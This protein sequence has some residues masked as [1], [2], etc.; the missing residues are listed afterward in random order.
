M[1]EAGGALSIARQLARQ[2]ARPS[3]IDPRQVRVIKEPSRSTQAA[4]NQSHQ[5]AIEE[6]SSS[7]HLR[8]V[9]RADQ[10]DYARRRREHPLEL[11]AHYGAQL[12]RISPAEPGARGNAPAARRDEGRER[13]C[14]LGVP[15]EGGNQTDEGCNQVAHQSQSMALRA[16]WRT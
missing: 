2:L 5:A 15:D 14:N 9:R 6:H 8:R 1:A 16:T 7:L 11:G 13:L 12:G 4:C 10:M 3:K